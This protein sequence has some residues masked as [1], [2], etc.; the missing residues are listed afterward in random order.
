MNDNTL[1]I[2][3]TIDNVNQ[4]LNEIKDILEKL[5][6]NIIKDIVADTRAKVEAMKEELHEI[7]FRTLRMTNYDEDMD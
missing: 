5:E 7:D 6:I 1:M 4:T 3:A 2:M